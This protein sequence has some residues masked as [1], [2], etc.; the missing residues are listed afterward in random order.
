MTFRKK[1]ILGSI[2]CFWLYVILGGLE[3]C[4]K[5]DKKETATIKVSPPSTYVGSTKC[6]SCH[7]KEFADWKKSDHFLAMQPA[8]DSSVLGDFSGT[9]F[10][11]DGVTNKFFKKDGKFI[12]N[13]QGDDGKNHDYEVLYAFG[14][15]PLQQYL[16]AFPGGRMQSTRVSWNSRDK[17]WFHQYPNQKVDHHDWLHWT[18][19]GQN[20]NTMCASCHSTDL[21]KNY[22]FTLD[23]YN[24]TWNEINVSCESCHGP[25]SKHISFISSAE[26]KNGDSLVNS[27]FLYAHSTNPQLQLNTCAP[28]HARKTDLSKNRMNTSEIMDDLIPQIISNEYYFADGQINQEDYEYGSFA[29]S[30]MFHNKVQCS[31]CHNPHSG[32]LKMIGNN[33]CMSCHQPK[34]NTKE[35]HF[36]ALETEGAQCINCHMPVKTFMGNDHRRDHSF[37]IPRPDQSIIYETPNTCTSCHKNKSNTWAADAIKKWYGPKRAYHFSDDLLP[38]SELS[39]KS[40]KHLIKLVR[41]TLQPEIARATAANYLGNIQSQQSVNGLLEALKDK[42]ALVRYHAV[43]SLENFPP[44]TWQQAAQQSLTDPVRAVRIAAADLYHR[45]PAEAIPASAKSA[46]AAADNENKKYLQH[47]TDF[48]VGNV[49]LADY[50]LQGNDHLNAIT[51]YIRGL[52]K[53]SLMN[54]ARL[55]LSAAYN[56]VGKN[57]EALKTLNDASAIDPKNER[58]FYN[59]GLL[60]YELSDIP[61]AMENF[62]KAM[63]LGSTNTGLYYN[64]G[65]LLQQQGKLKEA[66][67]VLLAGFSINQQAAN[68]NY[69]LAF[70][71]ANQNLTKKAKVHAMLLQKIDPNNP[72]YQGLFRGLGL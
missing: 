26:Y 51:H 62:K 44:E 23:S 41:D 58:V 27:G 7:A 22:D 47:Q 15:F 61:A 12:I 16:I 9:S 30:K 25:G 56:S 31:N 65:L 1:I 69:A 2:A 64:Y 5:F 70:L 8:N 46:Y 48:A 53:D 6:Q 38:G 13:A 20:W 18:G 42:K 10:T 57:A 37:R 39:E 3:G 55:N 52:Q 4:S 24:T 36:H 17:K 49:M 28:C 54:Y 40:E 19:N 50:E 72:E 43:R 33:L 32:K 60:Q 66:E 14:Y 67:Q 45:L 71:Y 59:L 34:Y 29:Q 11:S 21:Q 63:R 68:I 35:H